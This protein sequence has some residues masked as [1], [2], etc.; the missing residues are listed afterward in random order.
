MPPFNFVLLQS[1]PSCVSFD[2]SLYELFF[3]Q[4]K[5]G[6]TTFS[7]PAGALFRTQKTLAKATH[8]PHTHKKKQYRV[9]PDGIPFS[10]SIPLKSPHILQA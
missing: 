6:R 2:K 9:N 3:L 4:V 8:I 1:N 10:I 5:R 7:D